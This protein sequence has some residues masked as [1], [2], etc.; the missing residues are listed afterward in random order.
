MG[1]V[2]ER[3]TTWLDRWRRVIA[4]AIVCFLTPIAVIRIAGAFGLEWLIIEIILG[5]LLA[6]ILWVGIEIV[7]AAI[8][9]VSEVQNSERDADDAVLPPARLLSMTWFDRL[10]GRRV[11][12][13]RAR[14]PK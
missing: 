12:Y 4:I 13:R 8:V 6:P 5:I 9:S 3:C 10:F 2:L 14:H 1:R 11:G 7:F